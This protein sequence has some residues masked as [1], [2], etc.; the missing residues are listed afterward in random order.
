MAVNVISEI[1]SSVRCNK[2][3]EVPDENGNRFVQRHIGFFAAVHRRFNFFRSPGGI[4]PQ[5][6]FSEPKRVAH[7][8][9]SVAETPLLFSEQTF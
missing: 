1:Q 6:E 3:C 2:A 5:Q 8:D 9:A 4:I 7:A